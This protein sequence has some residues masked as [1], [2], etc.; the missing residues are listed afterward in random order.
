MK[1]VSS[2][3]QRIL[4]REFYRANAGLF[5]LAIGIS[6]GFMRSYEH[7]ALAEFFSASPVLMLVPISVWTIYTINVMK[8]NRD[9]LKRKE[10]E[11]IFHVTLLPPPQKWAGLFVTL[12]YQLLP[13]I[14]YGIFLM[15]FAIRNDFMDT[16]L[17]IIASLLLLVIVGAFALSHALHHSNQE[18]K[19]SLLSKFI[20]LSFTKPFPLFFPEWIARREPLMLFGTKIFSSLILLGVTQLYKTDIYDLR[21]LGLG[22]VIAFSAQVVLVWEVQ[23]F[24]NFYFPL[25]RNLPI[26]FSKRLLYFVCTLLILI[27]PELGMIIK[28]FPAEF[29]NLNMILSILFALSIPVF[30]YGWLYTKDRDQEKLMPF[31]FF[32]SISWILLILFKIPLWAIASINLNVGLACLKKFYYSF[33]YI[34][35]PED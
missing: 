17:M 8:F 2:I 10:N 23:R 11:F 32:F 30:F 3:L 5:F 33:E 22:I 28:N 29:N 31:L 15:A 1:I 4:V 21:L 26:P 25:N 13:A 35:K 19:V 6:A 16:I 24:D 9:V 14:L 34:S 20:N 7:V 12:F 18:K 27:I